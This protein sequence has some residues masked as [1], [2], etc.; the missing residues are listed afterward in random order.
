[1]AQATTAQ[2]PFSSKQSLWWIAPHSE[3]A[4]LPSESSTSAWQYGHRAP[5]LS[6]ADAFGFDISSTYLN[7]PERA[8]VL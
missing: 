5:L 3:Q 1:M 4:M 8:A 2:P 6:L 7:R